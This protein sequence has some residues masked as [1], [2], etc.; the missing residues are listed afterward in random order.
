MKTQ[1]PAIV[2]AANG[3]SD[4]S[5][6]SL[7]EDVCTSAL[8]A[9]Q[10]VCVKDEICKQ[11]GI[12]LEAASLLLGQ[13]P[14]ERSVP[15]AKGLSGLLRQLLG[16]DDFKTLVLGM[17]CAPIL[18]RTLSCHSQSP[19]VVEQVLGALA[20]FMMR[21]PAAAEDVAKAG[22]IEITTQLMEE[23]T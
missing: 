11:V 14:C 5:S 10:H 16:S 1:A 20:A 3:G 8:E 22:A 4:V 12:E 19:Q 7:E 18:T 2:E 13:L 6:S 15:V 9:L 21:L 23:N 17:D